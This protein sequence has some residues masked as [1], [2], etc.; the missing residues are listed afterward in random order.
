MTL[1]VVATVLGTTI[2][3][4]KGEICKTD[5]AT[6]VEIKVEGGLRGVYGMG[7]TKPEARGDLAEKIRG[8]ILVIDAYGAKRKEVQMPETVVGRL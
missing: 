6:L 8:Q 4:T 1:T 3:E 2:V 7:Q 5:F